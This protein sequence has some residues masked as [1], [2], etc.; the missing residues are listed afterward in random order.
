MAARSE[1]PVLAPMSSK[2][3]TKR[4]W[5]FFHSQNSNYEIATGLDGKDDNI[6]EAT[7]LTIMDKDCYQI[8]VDD[9][10]TVKNILDW[11]QAHFQPATNV[12]YERFVF[13]T[14]DQSPNESFDEYLCRLREMSKTYEFETF[15]TQMIRDRI[16][17]GSKDTH[18][19]GTI[20]RD[21]KLTLEN[22]IDF[23][24]KSKRTTTQLQK[25][26]SSASTS[27]TP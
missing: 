13:N 1:L 21:N 22:A 9:R 11:L 3:D 25:L 19:L 2:G 16:V 26:Q 6:R 27:E 5:K 20:L 15:H 12:I 8:S 17:I 10:K 23:C 24:R 7:L 18:A 14:S 4:K